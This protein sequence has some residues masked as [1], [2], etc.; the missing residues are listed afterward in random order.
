MKI[1]RISP[2]KAKI[3]LLT[4]VQAEKLPPEVLKKGWCWWLCTHGIYNSASGV[5]LDG[6]VYNLLKLTTLNQNSATRST[7]ESYAVL[8]SA[9]ILCCLMKSFVDIVSMKNRMIG[10]RLN[11]KLSLRVESSPKS[12]F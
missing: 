11:L 10:K 6:W 7:S 1:K 8:S 9:K 5:N 3:T 4:K 2:E 12:I